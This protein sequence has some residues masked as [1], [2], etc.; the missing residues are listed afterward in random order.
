MPKKFTFRVDGNP[1]FSGPLQSVQCAFMKANG[2][3]CRNRVVMG[4]DMCWIH[5]RSEK[6]LKLQDSTIPNGGKGLFAIDIKKEP[7]EVIFRP[8][9]TIIDYKGEFVDE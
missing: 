3:Q 6:K 7:N 4:I 8:R 5:T 2:V 9:Q 1:T